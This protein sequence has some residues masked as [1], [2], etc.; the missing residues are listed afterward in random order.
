MSEAKPLSDLFRVKAR[1]C[2]SVNIVTDYSDTGALTGYIATPLS[3]TVLRRLTQGLKPG[4][5]A[6]AWSVTG[7]YGAGKSACALFLARVLGNPQDPEARDLV[8]AADPE[9]HEE[10]HRAIP[11]LTE[12]GFL[13]VP[14]VGSREPVALA[15]LRGLA[16][17]LRGS[18]LNTE[19]VAQVVHWLDVQCDHMRQGEPFPAAMLS[20]AVERTAQAARSNSSKSLGLLILVD[21]LG[22][23]LEYSALNPSQGDIFL[24]QTLAELAARSGENPIGV[25]TILHQA[26]ER[27]AI[28]L[29][30]TQQREWA[31]VQGRFEDIPFLESPG[32]L[33]RLIGAAIEPQAAING[34]E[35][36]IAEEAARAR[37]LGIA[38]R[39]LRG[40]EVERVLQQCAPLHPTVALVLGRLFR[41]RLAQNERSLFAF[42]TSSEPHGL[43]DFLARAVWRRNGYRPFYRLDQLYDYVLTAV[44]SALYA[45]AQGK[46]WAEIED[47]LDRLPK[48]CMPLDARLVKAIGILGLLGDQRYLKASARVLSFALADGRTTPEDVGAAISRLQDWKIAVYRRHRDAYGL[49]EG[50]D[51]DLDDRFDKA[52]VQIDRIAN[53][54]SLLEARGQL[55]P[56]LA[57]RHL[58]KTGTLRHFVPWIVDA[59]DL[60]QVLERPFAPADGAVV[61]V[62][63]AP[64]MEPVQ[65]VEAVAQAAQHLDSVR[66]NLLLFA[67]PR[68]MTGIREALEELEAWEW[69]ERNTPELEGDSIARRELA[70]RQIEAQARL[71]SLCARCFD[72]AS[73][74]VSCLWVVGGEQRTFSSSAQLSAALSD[75]FDGAYAAA[76]EVHNELINRRVLSSAAAAARRILIERMLAAPDQYRLGIEGFPPELSMY[77]SVLERSRLHR[78]VPGTDRWA[79][80][81]PDEKDPCH[82][83]DLWLGIEA[84]LATTEGRR[85]QISE[86]FA[87]LREAPYGVRDGLLPVFLAVA[88]L[89]WE[90]EVALYENG[91]FIPK[92]DIAAF[93]RLMK[94]PEQFQ[95]QRYP[96][97]EA[98]SFLLEKFSTLLD[99]DALAAGG[100]TL[101]TAVRPILAFAR[102]LPQYTRT[103]S[104]IS[105]AAAAVR[106]AIFDAREPQRL[107]FEDLPR[108]LGMESLDSG[109]DLPAAQRFFAELKKALL[110]LQRAYDNL[111]LTIQDELIEAMRLPREI[112]AAR[113]EA[114]QRAAL[115]QDRVADLRLKAFALRVSDSQM[116][117]QE[118]L[119]SVA[120]VLASKP[121][122]QWSEQDFSRYQVELK[123]MAGRFRRMEEIVL[124]E[125]S[126]VSDAEAVQVF[127]IGIMAATGEEQREVVR[128]LPGEERE[129]QATVDALD[130]A[131]RRLGVSKRIRTA[132]I[133]ELARRSLSE[134]QAKGDA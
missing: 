68:D 18:R 50:S 100:A 37:E 51:I 107:L 129:V 108:A 45:H 96:L 122:K 59:A 71:N 64:G 116:P 35:P 131:L 14:V 85:R 4:S 23:L 105:S 31:K 27:Y 80:R 2:R 89:C 115:I 49:W 109:A 60:A 34:P 126:P 13:V 76:P 106:A 17:A 26:F 87:L 124:G 73:S 130:E 7:P 86:L 98:R 69:V 88:V 16:S 9:L 12:G 63:S 67:I 8:R 127:R 20:E 125:R 44:G 92:M 66:R 113:A 114:A 1:F 29:S 94:A 11:G 90:R 128:V 57:K 134:S 112:E 47:A 38:P 120:A 82:L 83:H 32:E 48:D 97:G 56:Y 5:Q 25:V 46:R 84:F 6:R 72:A 77:L 118:W 81:P 65:T 70:G 111:L 53:L 123:D 104:K 133:A 110:E 55:R 62:L 36:M 10:L 103:T 78:L 28:R 119:E 43:Q 93:E 95:I 19:K 61:F 79:F 15:L 42:L 30:P 101:L 33:L 121:P 39:E 54:A 102:Q 58:H 99:K 40:R 74:Y 24:L 132:A 41:S 52:L 3:R 22:K 91:S 75:I 117:R 21:E